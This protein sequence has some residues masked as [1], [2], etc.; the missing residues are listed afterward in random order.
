MSKKTTSFE[1]FFILTTRH[2][3]LF[4]CDIFIRRIRTKICCV[5]Y[6]CQLKLQLQNY[7][8]RWMIMSGKL[9]WSLCVGICT[10]GAAA[11]TGRPSGLPARIKEV[12]PECQSTCHSQG[13][14]G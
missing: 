9:K 12:A 3:F 4:I 11:M 7:S 2:Y 6:R 10:D 13:N 14:A 8:S 5:Y 1:S